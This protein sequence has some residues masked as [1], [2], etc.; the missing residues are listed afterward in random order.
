[1]KEKFGVLAVV[2]A[3]CAC[4]A[5]CSDSRDPVG[6][7]SEVSNGSPRLLFEEAGGFSYDPP[8]GWQIAEFPVS[9]YRISHGPSANEFAPNINVVDEVFS[10]T[11][12]AYVDANIE[13][14]RKVFPDFDP[15]KRETFQ[16]DDGED[17]FMLLYEN[18][19]LGN[20]LR[21]TLFV[22][23]KG[24]RKYAVTCTALADGG[25]SFDTVFAE[26]IRTFRLH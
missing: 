15:L 21:Q 13:A 7:E 11:L 22:F 17:G 19:M 4:L 8:P 5:S 18:E 25:E 26:S 1:M 23:A 9:K 16:T 20:L 3:V 6:R 2:L 24:D 10:G 12:E 14:M